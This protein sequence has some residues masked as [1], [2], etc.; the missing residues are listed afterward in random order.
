MIL[1]TKIVH[2][3]P[4]IDKFNICFRKK[5]LV[6]IFLIMKCKSKPKLFNLFLRKWRNS[7]QLNTIGKFFL[8]KTKIFKANSNLFIIHNPP[9]SLG[10]PHTPSSFCPLLRNFLVA[11]LNMT[12]IGIMI[13]VRIYGIKACFIDVSRQFNRNQHR[14]RLSSHFKNTLFYI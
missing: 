14:T 13:Y 3:I 1:A 10:D 2:I 7:M 8:W 5:N 4:K 6:R 11:P 9:R 12:A